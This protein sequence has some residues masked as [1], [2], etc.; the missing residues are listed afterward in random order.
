MIV[1][2]LIGGSLARRRFIRSPGVF[3]LRLRERPSEDDKWSG[4]LHARW[5]H[6]V[7]L[8]NRGY[9]RV[10]TDP[11]GVAD[12]VRGPRG[13]D[14]DDAKGLEE[15]TSLLLRL[16]DSSELELAVA[17]QDVELATGPY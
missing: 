3:A 7:L 1:G 15:P 17:A 5:V 16:D 4:K 2:A 10:L 14:A 8:V 11:H 12:M 9:A 13:V 6:D